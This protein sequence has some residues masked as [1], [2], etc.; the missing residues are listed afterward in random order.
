MSK[1][2]KRHAGTVAFA[3]G[4][5]LVAAAMVI[6]AT[7]GFGAILPRYN[8]AQATKKTTVAM[9][10]VV[11][12]TVYGKTEE[13]QQAATAANAAI[14][15]LEQKISWRIESSAV[16]KVNAAA[17]I[18]GAEC[19]AATLQLIA[20]CLD[21]AQKSDGAFDP[22]IL[23]VSRLWDFDAES[24]S[25][26][27]DSAVQQGL[28]VCSWQQL[29]VKDK[30]VS[31]AQSGAGIDLG[32]VGKGAACDEALKIYAQRGVSG[33]VVAVGGSVGVF[34]AKPDGSAWS[35]GV[36]DPEGGETDSLGT[37]TVTSGCVSTSGTYEKKR[38]FDGTIYHHIL[39]PRTGY[40]A[41]SELVSATV[42]CDSGAL[43]DALAT[44]CVVLG[45]EK[46]E[47]LLAQYSAAYL[48]IDQNHVIYSGG[49]AEKLFA[50]SSAKYTLQTP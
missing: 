23:P 18:S 40:P 19:D 24:F 3:A 32:G 44:A 13:E 35:I 37:L 50:L 41:K 21:V 39:D 46:A 25:P 22:C 48:L 42:I 49:G 27:A 30:T 1:W 36:R 20:Q 2:I 9:G 5:L 16:A 43:S 10:S 33:A 12:Q 28:A 17:G 11:S 4:G 7:G 6:W 26:P 45:R 15:Q 47:K 34:G 8:T 14:A 31:L 29:S 38:E